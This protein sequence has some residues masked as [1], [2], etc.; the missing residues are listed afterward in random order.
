MI[1]RNCSN[2]S[3][4]TF[5]WT[6]IYFFSGNNCLAALHQFLTPLEVG[7]ANGIFYLRHISLS[8]VMVS[9]SHISLDLNLSAYPSP[10]SYLSECVIWPK[11]PPSFF[12]LY[13]TFFHLYHSLQY[14]LTTLCSILEQAVKVL[15]HQWAYS[16]EKAKVELDYNPRSL[17][18]GLAEMLPWLKNLGLIKF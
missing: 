10:C 13:S 5:T 17:K 12:P 16:C 1:F 2:S 9:Y 7:T 3:T 8:L 4:M 14:S 6:R 15:K 18:D 11:W